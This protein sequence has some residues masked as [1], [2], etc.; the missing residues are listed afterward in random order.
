M[1]REST[2]PAALK[3]W[4]FCHAALLVQ[5]Q[6]DVVGCLAVVHAVGSLFE[7]IPS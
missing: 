6:C 7:E 3:A 1:V 5:Q 4:R 2:A